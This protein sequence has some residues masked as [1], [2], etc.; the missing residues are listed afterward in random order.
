[1][2][3]PQQN[4]LSLSAIFFLLEDTDFQFLQHWIKVCS[5]WYLVLV[6]HYYFLYLQKHFQLYN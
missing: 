3:L 4:P 5:F 1:M 6:V 2:V